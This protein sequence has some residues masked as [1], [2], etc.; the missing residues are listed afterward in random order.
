[1]LPEILYN[2]EVNHT[3]KNPLFVIGNARSGTSILVKLIRK[4]LKVSFGTESQFIIRYYNNLHRYGDL[5]DDAN[6][7][8]LINDISQERCFSRWKNRFGFKLD[9]KAVFNDIKRRT[10][11]GVLDSFFMQLAKFHAMDRWGDKTPEYLL[12]LPILN[13][14]FPDAQ[15]IH[16]VRDG[17]DVAL[18]N[19]RTHFGTKNLYLQALNWKSNLTRIENFFASISPSRYT[20]LR[21]ED[22]LSN[23][24]EVFS[25]L[26]EFLEIK[27]LDNQLLS[28]IAR[29]IGNDLKNDNSFKWKKKLTTRQVLIFDKLSTDF[30]QKYNYE[31]NTTEAWEPCR[32]RRFIWYA[33]SKLKTYL[34]NTYWK[35]NWYKLKLK[36]KDLTLP[37]RKSINAVSSRIFRNKSKQQA[38]QEY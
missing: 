34:H 20:E 28:F 27:D 10:Y 5:K 4:Y 16:I 32:I 30:L 38:I 19:F 18:S 22:L 8:L 14:L 21:Y 33:D 6:L 7:W 36:I 3:R 1:M 11:D 37:I 9:P 23:P 15:F 13:E 31:V 2:L 24:E 29:H 25:H 17:R 26:I 12:H 35:D